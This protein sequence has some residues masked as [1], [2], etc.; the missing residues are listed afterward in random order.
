MPISSCVQDEQKFELHSW[1]LK[2]YQ[3]AL[4]NDVF[5][6][7]VKEMLGANSLVPICERLELLADKF[8]V[9]GGSSGMMFDVTA[10]VAMSKLDSSL[11]LV[12]DVVQCVTENI[13]LRIRPENL[14]ALTPYLAK[15][16]QMFEL[17][18]FSSLVHGGVQ[19][20][21]TDE[22]GNCIEADLWSTGVLERFNPDGDIHLNSSLGQRWFTPRPWS[23]GDYDVVFTHYQSIV[24]S[25]IEAK[26]MGF[27]SKINV[28]FIQ[29]TRSDTPSF[30]IDFF[31][32]CLRRLI[33]EK[34]NSLWIRSVEV[35][36]VVPIAKLKDFIIPVGESEFRDAVESV[37]MAKG[38]LI[39]LSIRVV[40]IKYEQ[41]DITGA[42]RQKTR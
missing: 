11:D 27:T 16:G 1:T 29:V 13:S 5:F 9:V 41:R 38:V 40:G 30:K 23:S 19:C 33:A 6:N 22:N 37:V 18:F 8:F 21:T 28:R 34:K 2:E 24:D 15:N 31:K 35:F 39:V 26:R 42:K 3:E 14:N 32:T 7:H 20:Y 12:G 25:D 10:E 17:W 36:F 4:K